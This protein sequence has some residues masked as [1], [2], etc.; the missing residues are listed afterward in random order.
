MTQA[1]MTE[2]APR[3]APVSK[4]YGR[5]ALTL[6]VMIYTVNF[7][8]RQILSSIGES[9]KNDLHLTDTQ[10]GALTG[11]F[12]AF[13]YTVLG[14]PIARLADKGHRP[15][16]M[17]V[18]LAV[19]S[20][21]TVLS[22]VAR[23]YAVL[24]IARAG[25][26][27]G[28]AG[29][30]P[31]A[32]SLLA[33]YFPKEKRATALAIYSTGISIGTLLGFAIGGIIAQNYG[34]RAAFL[35]AG[36]PGLF[37]AL[38]AVLTLKE[39]RTQLSADARRLH[40]ASEHISVL[41]VFSTLLQRPT[42]WLFGLGGALTSFVSYAH[43]FFLNSFFLRN[44]SAELTT[45]AAHFHMAPEPGKPP[46]AFIS[47][48]MGLASGIGGGFGSWMGGV[49]ADYWGQ[50]NMKNFVIFPLLVPII[51]TP[52]LWYA[53][54]TSNMML[55]LPLML[56]P[57]I[58]VGAWWGPV[59][60]GVQGLVPVAMRAMA[61]AV[62]LFVINIIGL[63]FGPT[64]FG[65]VSDMM[66]NHYL[67][68]AGL[69]VGACK[70]AVGEAKAACAA[71]SAHGIKTTVY[72]STAI[73]PFAMLCFFVSRFTLQRDLDRAEVVAPNVSFGR[74]AAWMI[75]GCGITGLP[76]GNAA[77]MFFPGAPKSGL[78][79]PGMVGGAVVAAIIGVI[80]TAWMQSDAR[81]RAQ[82][83]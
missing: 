76:L 75:L 64:T 58:A 42:F 11:I 38:M 63:G 70:A 35:V 32:H 56:I 44:H 36:A 68:G 7:L 18:S 77:A 60:G 62:L 55:A 25:V 23:N 81:R 67:A 45:L 39:P 24:A 17:T 6:L 65:V 10:L 52:I 53:V 79:L 74:A 9:I 5:Y 40:N 34:W 46:L 49:V 41:S 14:I 15:W 50:R 82:A 47:L 13:V 27:V 28:E 16:V 83:A 73:L 12:F 43:S 2:A 59:Y 48:A 30:S 71:A 31:T 57:N 3:F 21:F 33:D 51:S 29:C 66:T 8:D 1:T 54:G 78:W 80:L 22:S 61:A 4:N 69:D 37:F 72:L 19:W 26:G 20:G